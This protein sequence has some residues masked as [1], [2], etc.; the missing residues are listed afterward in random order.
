MSLMAM[1][2]DPNQSWDN[3]DGSDGPGARLGALAYSPSQGLFVCIQAGEAILQYEL[4]LIKGDFQVEAL[5]GAVDINTSFSC[6]FPQRHLANNDY[7]WGLVWGHGSAIAQGTTIAAGD[8]LYPHATE[9][10]V[11]DVA[12][13]LHLH[14][15]YA[16]TTQGTT[17]QPV[18]IAVTWPAIDLIV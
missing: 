15:C 6:C 7:G 5:D 18:G 4:C 17:G 3:A 1:G 12:L 10:R 2:C 14:G 9:G 13:A 8:L 16:T 11:S